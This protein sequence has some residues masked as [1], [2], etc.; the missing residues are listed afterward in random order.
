MKHDFTKNN[1]A[2]GSPRV[3]VF[4]DSIPKG[5]YLEGGRVARVGQNAVTL[6]AEKFGL[7]IIEVI[8]SE[9]GVEKEA[10]TGDGELVNSGFLNGLRVKESKAAM[11]KW[12]TER[13]LGNANTT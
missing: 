1:T 6:T 2:A 12:L 13:G 4:G 3:T 11:I 8:K 10:F 9:Q 5:L 7:D